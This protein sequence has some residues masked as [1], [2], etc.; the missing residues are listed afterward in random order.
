VKL[1]IIGLDNSEHQRELPDGCYILG[2]ELLDTYGRVIA[3]LPDFNDHP[4]TIFDDVVKV[5][6]EAGL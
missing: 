2:D 5:I 1:L 4:D 3:Y 6:K